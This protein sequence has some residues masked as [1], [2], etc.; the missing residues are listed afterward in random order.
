[1][2]KHKINK[3]KEPGVFE[4]SNARLNPQ[5]AVFQ[6]IISTD[7]LVREIPIMTKTI[8]CFEESSS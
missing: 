1:M 5:I 2:L 3:K 7:F 6:F 4:N 8:N